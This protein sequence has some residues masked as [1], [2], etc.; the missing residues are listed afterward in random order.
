MS[1]RFTSELNSLK[2]STQTS[3][4]QSLQDALQL[5]TQEMLKAIQATRPSCRGSEE[6]KPERNTSQINQPN[7]CSTLSSL[8]KTWRGPAK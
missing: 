7:D 1:N 8:G 5:Q 4:S 2:I 6:G 3:F